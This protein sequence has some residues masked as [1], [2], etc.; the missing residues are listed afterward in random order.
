MV[1]LTFQCFSTPFK[2]IARTRSSIISSLPMRRGTTIWMMS[3]TN[4]EEIAAASFSF[5]L[6]VFDVIV[7]RV[8]GKTICNDEAPNATNDASSH[9]LYP[10]CRGKG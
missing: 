8:V 4:F 2:D 9:C 7:H 10:S 3:K 1:S 5:V 6:Y